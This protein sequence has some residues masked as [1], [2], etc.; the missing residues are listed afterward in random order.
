MNHA[1]S[2][3]RITGLC[4][5][6]GTQAAQ[7][8]DYGI[9]ETS[10]RRSMCSK[11]ECLPPQHCFPNGRQACPSGR[12][13]LRHKADSPSPFVIPCVLAARSHFPD[14]VPVFWTNCSNP[15]YNG[16]IQTV[17]LVWEGK[18]QHQAGMR[19]GGRTGA[20]TDPKIHLR[21]K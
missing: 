15:L 7:F 21:P 18:G 19:A 12:C 17:V 6:R 13:W 8:V 5:I 10:L 4:A 14:R 11:R 2:C 20:R 3:S 9:P 16:A 1:S